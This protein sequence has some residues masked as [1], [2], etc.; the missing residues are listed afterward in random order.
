VKVAKFMRFGLAFALALG[1]FGLACEGGSNESG[2]N[3]A[4]AAESSLDTRLVTHA[5]LPSKPSAAGLAYVQAVAAAHASAD[6][7]ADSKARIDHLLTALDRE[8]PALDGTA[9]LLHYEL[10][11]R[12]AELL[13]ETGEAERV[14]TLLEPWVGTAISLPIDRASAR[15]LV[16]VGDAAAQTGDHA[17]AMGSYARSLEMLSLLLEE[18]EP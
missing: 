14:L 2:A 11:A 4:G 6:R 7:I 9:E 1:L 16:A 13:L 12:T 17:L 18:A 3:E 15:C 5:T 8:P 10:L